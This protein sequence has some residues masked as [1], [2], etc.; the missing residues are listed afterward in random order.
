MTTY[1]F[2]FHFFFLIFLNKNDDVMGMIRISSWLLWLVSSRS[3][4]I[5]FLKKRL[6]IPV[7]SV[8]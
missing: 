3:E 8:S 2:D 1:S 4:Y 7:T 6:L 5:K